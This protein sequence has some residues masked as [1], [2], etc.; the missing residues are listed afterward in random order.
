MST[1][2]NKNVLQK[3]CIA[4][5]SVMTVDYFFTIG[6]T[7]GFTGGAETFLAESHALIPRFVALGFEWILSLYILFFKYL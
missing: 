6:N 3:L 7:V 5:H 1:V 2:K 4:L